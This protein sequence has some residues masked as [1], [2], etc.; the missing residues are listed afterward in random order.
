MVSHGDKMVYILKLEV[1]KGDERSYPL[2][3]LCA[4]SRMVQAHCDWLKLARLTK[5][6]NELVSMYLLVN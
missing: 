2:F 4:V 3:L 5:K 1:E 6:L